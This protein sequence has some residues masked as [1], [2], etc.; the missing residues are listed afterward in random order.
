MMP[1]NRMTILA[2]S[3]AGI[4]PILCSMVDTGDF[5]TG[6]WG[7]LVFRFVPSIVLA[8]LGYRKTNSKALP[9][10]LLIGSVVSTAL[11]VLFVWFFWGSHAA[12]AQGGLVFVFYLGIQWVIVVLAAL[13]FLLLHTK[14]QHG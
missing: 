2:V 6:S 9:H 14:N 11:S 4:L 12:D 7:E 3:L 1:S 10:I 5:K 8:C 13:S